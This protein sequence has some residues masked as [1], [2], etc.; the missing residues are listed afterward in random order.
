MTTDL[1]RPGPSSLPTLEALVR[2]MR[3][4]ALQAGAL[5]LRFYES[6]V[7]VRMKD[8]GSPVT[9]ADEEASRLLLAALAQLAPGIPAISEE[10]VDTRQVP[11]P[12]SRFFLVDPLDG[13]KE[14]IGRNGEFTV[15]L[16][17][18]DGGRPVA[19]VVYVPARQRLFSG[20]RTEDG[21]GHAFEHPPEG[22]PR[23]IAARRPAPEGLVVVA[24]RSHRDQRTD[25]YLKQFRVTSFLT[26]GSSLK[27]CLLAAGEAD[28]YPRLGRT[29]EWDTAA[30]HAVLEAAG[31][32]VT[33][34]DGT[35]LEY[36]KPGFENPSFVC[37]GARLP[38]SNG[39]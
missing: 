3:E 2:G 13:T 37:W 23:A 24:S 7:A 17:L 30:G 31:G 21:R 4:A 32:Q 33:R 8:D 38:T 22:P 20:W 25:E 11:A 1:E 9:Q 19:G 28:L 39:R 12:G 27:F 26:A 5:I 18:I 36:G 34:L 6:E 29:M 35:P 14:F 10:A 16:A 15:N